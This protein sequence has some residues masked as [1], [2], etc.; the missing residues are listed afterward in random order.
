M[1]GASQ[2]ARRS[3][4]LAVVLSALT[5]PPALAQ[6]AGDVQWAQTILKEKGFNIGGRANGQMTPG[7]K[8]AL[9]AYQKSVG[10]PQTGQLDQATV[11]KMMG[12]RQSKAAPTMGNLAQQRPG[13]GGPGQAPRE[14]QRE[15]APRAAPTQR[16][17][18]NGAE[19]G[20]GA[21][22][23]A[24]P[25]ATGSRSSS[26]STSSGPNTSS[27]SAPTYAPGTA[28]IVPRDT[29]SRDASQGP[30]PQAAPRASVT[31]TTPTGQPAPLV[32][33][34]ADSGSLLPAWVMNGLR[35]V[36]MAVV[37]LTVGGIGFA[38][39]RSGRA[40]A[41]KPAPRDDGPRETR[42]EPSF[43]GTRREELTTG[44]LPPLTS[45]GRGRR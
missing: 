41:P 35:Y 4:A 16:I 2:R 26:P 14:P 20:G 27:A 23:S 22:F 21:Q 8:A 28:A 29:A 3:V 39:W 40:S 12:E 24:G 36:V 15:V 32:E 18:G 44:S 34:T 43:G 42:R 37:G 13:G 19:L 9:S 33:P 11:N 30:V 5:V 17:E 6:Q 7:T 45:G 38:W 10:L 1:S 25:P 31:A